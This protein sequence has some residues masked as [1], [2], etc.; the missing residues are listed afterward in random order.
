ML[1]HIPVLLHWWSW[2]AEMRYNWS[3]LCCGYFHGRMILCWEVL[4]D[5]QFSSGVWTIHPYWQNQRLW[6]G[7]WKLCAVVFTV[8]CIFLVV[9]WGRRPCQLLTS[10]LWNHIII[11]GRCKWP[12]FV[13]FS[14]PLRHLF[15]QQSLG[16]IYL[17]NCCSH[18]SLLWFCTG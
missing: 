3:W 17:N 16:V 2:R 5:I 6:W 8:P 11:W 10:L 9:L 1:G 12:V 15:C 18:C 13:A 4:V 14:A 7:Q